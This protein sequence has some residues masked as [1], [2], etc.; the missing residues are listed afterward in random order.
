MV[1]HDVV[2]RAAAGPRRERRGGR[3]GARADPRRGPALGTRLRARAR[4][5]RSTGS[6]SR[7]TSSAPC[8][9]RT[10][11]PACSASR[12][13]TATGA[14]TTSSNGCCRTTCSSA[15][16]PLTG[17][18]SAQA[19]VAVPGA[20]PPGRQQ[21]RRRLR[22]HRLRGSRTRMARHP[23]RTALRE[24]LVE[25]GELVPVE[26]EGLRGK[27]FVL[28]E[29]VELLAAPPE[30]PAS[31][32][33]LSPFDPL[34]WDRGLLGSLFDFDYV[35]ELFFPPAKRRFGWY[36]LPILFRDRF[37]GRIEPQIDRAG[38]CRAGAG[39]LVGGRL[40]AATCRRL[41][42]RDALC[43]PDVS[44]LR[45]RRP[46]RMGAA[47]REGEETLP[48]SPLAMSGA[49]STAP[50]GADGAPGRDR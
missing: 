28:R 7:R 18:A 35:W 1:P 2:P 41:R 39:S 20:R 6:G 14:T 21:W 36:V 45:G 43:A 47:P 17:S 30:P 16:S 13:A 38:G 26:V 40:R 9:R 23:G 12:D 32:A 49:S 42:G 31:V 22:G 44:P 48:R 11:S 3:T 19:A 46:P 29:E 27:R 4:R 33:F 8:S 25:E 15:R 34:V 24:E 10:L 37:V 5:R 50:C